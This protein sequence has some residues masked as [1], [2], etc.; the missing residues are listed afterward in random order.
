MSV[1]V[2]RPLHILLAGTLAAL[3]AA[4]AAFT[5]ASAPS[6]VALRPAALLEALVCLPPGRCCGPLSWGV[7]V[8][9]RGA[10][11]GPLFLLAVL[12]LVEIEA[13]RG[14]RGTAAGRSLGA[15]LLLRS[16]A[17]GA[18]GRRSEAIW[19]CFDGRCRAGPPCCRWWLK[20]QV[21]HQ[22]AIIIIPHCKT[23]HYVSN[24]KAALL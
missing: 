3:L 17:A 24:N 21:Q 6:A 8:G 12:L 13:E 19:L 18:A 2:K 1:L 11:T 5:I 23:Q 16:A 22:A 14:C 9:R 4:A 15:P 10:V 20:G 7:A